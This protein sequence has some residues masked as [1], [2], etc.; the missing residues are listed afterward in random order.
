MKATILI[1]LCGAAIAG[2][3]S[4]NTPGSATSDQSY[5][6][7][8]AGTGSNAYAAAPTTN[9]DNTGI[10]VR[11]RDADAQTAGMQ[12]QNTSDIDLTAAIRRGIMDRKLSV[13]AQNVKIITQNGKVTLRGPVNSLDE[14]QTIGQL[15]TDVAGADNVDNQLEIIPNE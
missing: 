7:A 6:T 12:G 5:S 1:L 11:D 15:A 9:P 13:N 8:S 3:Q 14:K 10:N 4:S 2:C